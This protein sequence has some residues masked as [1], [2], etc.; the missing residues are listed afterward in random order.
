MNRN[1]TSF[2]LQFGEWAFRRAELD[3]NQVLVRGKLAL[4][5]N[6]MD[7][8]SGGWP[9]YDSSDS[10]RGAASLRFTPWTRTTFVANYEHGQMQANVALPM[11]AFDARALWQASGRPTTTDAAW[12]TASRAVGINR[13]TT[14][15]NLVV[16][17]AGGAAPFV[18]TTSNA[19]N[20]RLLESTYDDL[21]IPAVQRA[22]LTL[23]PVSEIP[24]NTS[25]SGPGAKRDTNFDR[26]VTTLEQRFTR[27]LTFEL[28]Y[29][30]ERTKQW[31][32]SPVNNLVLYT[33]DPNLTIPNPNGSAT[34]IATRMPADFTSTRSGRTTTA[35]RP[36]MCCAARS[37]GRSRRAAGAR[38][39]SR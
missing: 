39:I 15:R 27:E 28:A 13:N 26:L 22:G 14:V 5:L 16:T 10:S 20:F 34:P 9:R 29:L 17:D 11:T 19:A 32:I 36:T 23:A 12:T 38:I 33:G 8:H 2:R 1:R 35:A 25:V 31:V 30:H 7:Q 37:R 21:N 3:H 6:G 24:F 4:R 18:L